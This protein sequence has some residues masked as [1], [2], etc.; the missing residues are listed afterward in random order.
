M[1]SRRRGRMIV[2][3]VALAV[4]WTSLQ[5]PSVRAS[6]PPFVGWTAV[7]PPLTHQY[8]PNSLDDCVAGRVECVE[9][10][11]Q[12]MQHRMG[13]LAATCDH[14]A[15]FALAYL[16]TT[17]SY[18]QYSETPGFLSDPAFVDHEDAAFA[19]MYFDAM[20]TGPLAGSTRYPRHGGSPWVPRIPGRSAAWVTCCWA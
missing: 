14:K 11:I 2:L 7:L 9:S 16:R 18:L 10:T 15:V 3:L 17:Q 8:D 20:T 4:T 13:P 5:A 6:D 19:Q 1:G 12:L